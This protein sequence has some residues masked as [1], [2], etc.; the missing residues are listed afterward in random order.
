MS[1]AEIV[2]N[3]LDKL[4]SE[5]NKEAKLAEQHAMQAVSHALNRG[6]C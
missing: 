3:T 5:I 4:A 6:A 2:T 1:T